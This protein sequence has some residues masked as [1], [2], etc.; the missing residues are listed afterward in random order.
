MIFEKITDHRARSL[1]LIIHGSR[2][3]TSTAA[4]SPTPLAAH[5]F[6]SLDEHQLEQLLMLDT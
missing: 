2:R 1:R 3:S 4:H 6:R 5:R